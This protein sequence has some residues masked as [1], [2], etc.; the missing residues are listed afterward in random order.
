MLFKL[1]TKKMIWIC[2]WLQ[3]LTCS[4]HWDLIRG[5]RT[6]QV[7]WP[8]DKDPRRGRHKPFQH[9]EGNGT[10][11]K[12]IDT[13]VAHEEGQVLFFQNKTG[14]DIATNKWKTSLVRVCDKSIFVHMACSN[15]ERM[16]L[17]W[18]LSLIRPW[19]GQ[20]IGTKPCS[21]RSTRS[22]KQVGALWTLF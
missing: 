6:A 21:N 20:R 9:M 4:N 13:Q 15:I 12:T 2:L 16:I 1:A 18:Y 19:T 14:N 7:N 3:R 10:Q 5:L 11:A 22:T 8:T 17:T